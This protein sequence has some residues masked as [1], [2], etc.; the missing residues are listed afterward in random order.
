MALLE[1]DDI[2]TYYGNIHAL[3]GV[4]LAVEE[5]E[6]VTL[7]GAN[8]A[9]K[10]TTLN[11]ICG[12]I[13]PRSGS[14]RLDGRD[15][16]SVAPHK[17]VSAGV[18]QVPEG[19]RTFARL[20]VEENLR[21]GGF[22]VSDQEVK[23]GV[24]R[25]FEMFPRLLERR[26]QI[27]GTLSGGEQQMLAMGRALMSKPKVLLLDEPSMGLAPVLVDA[28]FDTIRTLHA[29]GTTILL[30]EQNARMA[31]QVADRGYVIESGR[32]LLTDSAD[33]PARERGGPQLLPRHRLRRS[34]S[35]C[36]GR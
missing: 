18:V 27:A 1:V 30:I 33:E 29:A 23:D 9:G 19:R 2:H 14:V 36:L 25:A 13:R 34:A 7:I 6:I 21:M 17:I 8:G 5:G 32:I 12:I 16:G 4:S 24:A 35:A 26:T 10:T 15:L 28:I 11:T 22:T 31:L 3:K 20:T